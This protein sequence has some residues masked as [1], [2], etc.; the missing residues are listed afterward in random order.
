MS[1]S[2]S[3]TSYVHHELDNDSGW[4]ITIPKRMD[5]KQPSAM[6]YLN[7]SP[8]IITPHHFHLPFTITASHLDYCVKYL[9]F[10][11]K[12]SIRANDGEHENLI[13]ALSNFTRY[14]KRPYP[15]QVIIKLVV[16][17]L[18]NP[19]PNTKAEFTATK[20]EL[21]RQA[22]H[23]ANKETLARIKLEFLEKDAATLFHKEPPPS[24]PLDPLDDDLQWKDVLHTQRVRIQNEFIE[25]LRHQKHPSHI[26]VMD[27]VIELGLATKFKAPYESP[28]VWKTLASSYLYKLK[29]D[30]S[31]GNSIEQ[32]FIERILLTPVQKSCTLE[33]IYQFVEGK[34][35][36]AT[37][38]HREMQR[39]SALASSRVE[40]LIT[41][42]V[43]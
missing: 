23:Y 40:E 5:E 25:A 41:L 15:I 33:M 37:H 34:I 8:S 36:D 10:L 22:S 27:F 7:I 38:L 29:I 2:I 24:Q 3:K 31:Q 16:K 4:S 19:V 13:M 9:R 26:K 12:I 17:L 43:D 11:H 32:L 1:A 42:K 20:Y 35:R 6:G 21:C 28:S 39:M 30:S 14:L 18:F